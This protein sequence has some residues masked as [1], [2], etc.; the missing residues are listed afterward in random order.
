M[1]RDL[2]KPAP[3]GRLRSLLLLLQIDLWGPDWLLPWIDESDPQRALS[4]RV[5]RSIVREPKDWT[6]N[7]YGLTN[8]ADGLGVYAADGY[9]S[10]A[11]AADADKQFYPTAYWRW[12]INRVVRWH[13]TWAA[14]QLAEQTSK[15][16]LSDEQLADPVAQ[17]LSSS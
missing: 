16:L 6:E 2:V 9:Q 7:D 17:M 13:R 14:Q 1:T 10:I 3:L 5:I 12:M 11:I 8:L 4:I 15:R